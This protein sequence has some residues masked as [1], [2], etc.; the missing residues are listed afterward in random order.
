[1]IKQLLNSAFASSEELW[2][3]R[4]LV[5]RPVRAIRVTR[6]GLEPSAIT[7]GVLG[8]LSRQAWQVTSHPKSPRTTGNEAGDLGGRYPTPSSISIILQVIRKPN[9]IIVN[10]ALGSAYEKFDVSNEVTRISY[11][12]LLLTRGSGNF[13]L[14]GLLSLCPL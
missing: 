9:S 4:I 14:E 6:G 13:F 10:Y 3:S 7:R 12:D 5:P 2:R 1:M 8:E 11:P